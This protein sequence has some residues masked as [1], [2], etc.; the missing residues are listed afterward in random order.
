[1]GAERNNKRGSAKHHVVDCSLS[2]SHRLSRQRRGKKLRETQ[3]VV[4]P[5]LV[6][7]QIDHP[8]VQ[9]RINQGQN[10]SAGVGAE[11]VLVRLRHLTKRIR[12]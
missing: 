6:P 7:D 9:V 12:P 2:K 1:M 10:K 5:E 11:H 8:V 4:I 3:C